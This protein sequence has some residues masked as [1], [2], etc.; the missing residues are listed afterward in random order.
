MFFPLPAR[1]FFLVNAQNRLWPHSIPEKV[2]LKYIMIYLITVLLGNI[3]INFPKLIKVET[4]RKY[5]Y[6][7]LAVD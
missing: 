5:A 2:M 4:S 1:A 6:S 3:F 7:L